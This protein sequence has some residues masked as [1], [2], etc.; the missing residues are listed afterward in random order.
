MQVTLCIQYKTKQERKETHVSMYWYEC[1]HISLMLITIDRDA[2]QGGMPP[3]D[4]TLL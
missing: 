1:E 2:T 3:L 4:E